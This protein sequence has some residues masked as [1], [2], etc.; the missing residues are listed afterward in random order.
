MQTA[1][2]NTN[3]NAIFPRFLDTPRTLYIHEEDNYRRNTKQV[4]SA[5]SYSLEFNKVW[6]NRATFTLPSA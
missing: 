6:H 3:T 5:C 1:Q 2:E 4:D